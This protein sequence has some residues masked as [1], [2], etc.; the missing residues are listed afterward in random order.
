[1]LYSHFFLSIWYASMTKYPP[2]PPQ[3]KKSKNYI[4][5]NK[6]ITENISNSI[7]DHKKAGTKIIIRKSSYLMSTVKKRAESQ[8]T[9]LNFL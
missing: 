9:F 3:K 5:L 4:T 7:L 2:P 1:M 6:T 8:K